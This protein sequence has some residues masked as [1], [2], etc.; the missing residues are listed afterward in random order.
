MG[1]RPRHGGSKQFGA[2]LFSFALL[3]ICGIA[4]FFLRVDQR[5]EET[6]PAAQPDITVQQ[7]R[8]IYPYSVIPGGVLNA[9]ELRAKLRADGVA[10]RHYAGFDVDSAGLM[11]VHQERKVYVSYRIGDRIYWTRNRIRLPPGEYLLTDGKSLVRA[12]CGNRISEQPHIAVSEAEPSEEAMDWTPD[13]PPV[14]GF[15]T[16][17]DWVAVAPGPRDPEET[18]PV[19]AEQPSPALEKVASIAVPSPSPQFFSYPARPF[20]V[21]FAPEPR[22]WLLMAAGLG[23]FAWR[24]MARR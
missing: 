6:F 3:A 22:T 5:K 21:L 4:S 7:P 11:R 18:A 10:A 19:V 1:R 13:P 24:S 9:E 15:N 2:V 20:P 8:K 17:H 16:E 14:L 23:V 12:R